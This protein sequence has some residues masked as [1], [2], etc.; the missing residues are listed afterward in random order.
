VRI[1]RFRDLAAQKTIFALWCPTAAGTTV[2]G[3]ALPVAGSGATLVRLAD[4]SATGRR[5]TLGASG[6]ALRL[7]L[8]ETPIFVIVDV[9]PPGGGA[10]LYAGREMAYTCLHRPPE[11]R[12]RP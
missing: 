1:N 4:K 6:G 7:D 10:P 3:C 5:T 9:G 2:S 12:G 11:R 8:S